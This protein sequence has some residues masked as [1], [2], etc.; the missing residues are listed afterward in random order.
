MEP[1]VARQRS[2][3]VGHR[4]HHVESGIALAAVT[5]GDELSVGVS[6]YP[7]RSGLNFCSEREGQ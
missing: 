6:K 7:A 5:V 1:K 2:R 3:G 4:M